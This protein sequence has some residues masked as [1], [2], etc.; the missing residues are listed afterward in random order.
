MNNTTEPINAAPTARY[1]RPLSGVKNI[2]TD[3]LYEMGYDNTLV[4]V[5][6]ERNIIDFDLVD[7]TKHVI[8]QLEEYYGESALWG[9][10]ESAV[11]IESLEAS[12]T[13][14]LGETWSASEGTTFQER[15]RD[16]I[17][18]PIENLGLKAVLCYDLRNSSTLSEELEGVKRNLAIDYRESDAY[19]PHI[20]LVVYSPRNSRIIALIVCKVNVERQIFDIAYWKLKLQTNE[21]S[22]AIKYYLITTDI[23]KTLKSMDLPHIHHRAIIET[24]IDS[25]YV[26]TAKPFAE[27]GKVKLFEHF[28]D[29]LKQVIKE[30]E[31]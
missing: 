31:S 6:I 20:D 7:Y 29:D 26:L 9:D 25:T 24:E 22:A 23:D 27:N 15:I 17:T 11:A 30:S 21:N 12:L 8:Y 5:L 10:L 19:L 1:D 16:T 28:I 2:L 18:E 13:G 14:E 4:D 3:A